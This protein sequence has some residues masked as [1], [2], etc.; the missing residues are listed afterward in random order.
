MQPTGVQGASVGKPADSRPALTGLKP[1]TSFA[2]STAAMILC[3]SICAG[4][5]SCTRMPWMLASALRRAI[6]PK[7]SASLVSF[8][9]R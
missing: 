3:G 2:G 8:G 7:S 1:S 9:S 6:S 5:G 4:R